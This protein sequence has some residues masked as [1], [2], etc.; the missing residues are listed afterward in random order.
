MKKKKINEH[1]WDGNLD[2]HK[3]FMREDGY[4]G[5]NLKLFTFSDLIRLNINIYSLLDQ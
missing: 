2:N 4:W 1:L 3:T 5:T